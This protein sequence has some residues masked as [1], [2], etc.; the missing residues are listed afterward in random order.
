M[1]LMGTTTIRVDPVKWDLFTKLYPNRGS[2][3]IRDYIEQLVDSSTPEFSSNDFEQLQGQLEKQLRIEAE[4]KLRTQALQAKIED[5]KEQREIQQNK[6]LSDEQQEWIE[7]VG[8]PIVERRG[9]SESF[10]SFQNVT[11][12]FD[13]P[14]GK[15][16]EV[17]AESM[18]KLEET[19]EN[20]S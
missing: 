10:K 9:I 3:M 16:R 18:K 19:N 4:M 12:R 20:N 17:I 5:L 14:F 1:P 11:H 15:Y 8:V 6:S 7:N 13:F 2:K